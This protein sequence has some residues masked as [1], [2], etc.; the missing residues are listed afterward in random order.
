VWGRWTTKF[1][2]ETKSFGTYTNVK[3]IPLTQ[4]LT[5]YVT[6]VPGNY[7]YK[8]VALDGT[9]K[10]GWTYAKMQQAYYLVDYDFI[11]QVDSSNKVVSGTK[12]NF[13]VRI[14][15]ISGSPVAYDYSSKN[16]PAYAKAYDE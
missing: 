10:N 14:E 11:V 6:N 13:P 15:L 4:F 9:Y 5:D 12:I 2:V 1:S 16:P 8:I 3:V 7:T